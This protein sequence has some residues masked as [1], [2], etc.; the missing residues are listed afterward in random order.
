LAGARSEKLVPSFF[1]LG[2]RFTCSFVSY[3]RPSPSPDFWPLGVFPRGP[4]DRARDG[5]A[6]AARAK[7]LTNCD[8]NGLTRKDHAHQGRLRRKPQR[9]SGDD[10]EPDQHVLVSQFASRAARILEFWNALGKHAST[11]QNSVFLSHRIGLRPA[12]Q[13]VCSLVVFQKPSNSRLTV[14]VPQF[15][16]TAAA[17][18]VQV[19]RC[20]AP[21]AGH[22]RLRQSVA[23]GLSP[24]CRLRKSSGFSRRRQVSSED[25]RLFAP[26]LSLP[27]GAVRLS[28]FGQRESTAR[29]Q[30]ARME[31]RAGSLSAQHR[32]IANGQ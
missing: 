17:V 14:K 4:S 7:E 32:P 27:P 29:I 2:P 21:V 8:R 24:P 13:G 10:R 22:H 19:A 5:A 1:R 15:H 16:L 9:P 28:L 25:A 30:E 26:P 20:W 11:F 12:K 3:R 18:V 23:L 6:H 31:S